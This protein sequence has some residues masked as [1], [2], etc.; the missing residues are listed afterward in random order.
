MAIY[1]KKKMADDI[2]HNH[3]WNIAELGSPTL[4]DEAEF[5]IHNQLEELPPPSAGD[6][7]IFAEEVIHNQ[8]DE[9]SAVDPAE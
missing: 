3:L 7:R 5:I 8:I 1:T 9:I 6:Q 2:I 4:T